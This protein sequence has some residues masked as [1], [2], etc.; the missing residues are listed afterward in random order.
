MRKNHIKK[1]KRS[2]LPWFMTM[3]FAFVTGCVPI[4]GLPVIPAGTTGNPVVTVS[5]NPSVTFTAPLNKASGVAFNQKPSVTFNEAMDPATINNSTLKLTGPGTEAVSGTVAYA[6]NT[7]TFTPTTGLTPNTVYSATITTGAKNPAGNSLSENFVWTFTTGS[8]PDTTSPV[9][10]STIP[11]ASENNVAINLKPT[12]TFSEPMDPLTLNTDIFSLS[13]GTQKVPGKV[14]YVGLI[15]TFTPD[16]NLAAN[17][18]YTATVTTQAKDLAGNPLAANFSW[19]F[20]TGVN[21]DTTMPVVISTTPLNNTDHQAIN[22]KPTVTFSEPMDPLTITTGTFILTGPGTSSVSGTVTY[23]GTTATFMPTFELAFDTLYT[24]TITTGARDL[25]GNALANNTVWT[26]RTGTGSSSSTGGNGGTTGGNNGNTNS[27]DNTA[28]AVTL[29][30]PVNGAPGIATNSKISATF[31]EAMSPATINDTTF[32][33]KQGVTPVAGTV[34]YTGLTA[35]FTPLVGLTANTAYTATITTGAKDLA[36]NALAANFV[37]SFTTSAAADT[38]APTVTSTVPAANAVGVPFNQKPAAT[39]SEAMD[40]ATINTLTFTLKQGITPVTGTVT[41]VGQTATFTPAVNLTAST[42]YTAT[43]TT[44]AKDLAGNALAA[45]V[46]WSFTTGAIADTTPP[47][48]TSTDPVDNATGVAFSQKPS[49]VFSEAMDPATINNVTF[50]LKQ[51]TTSVS[52]TVSYLGNT[53]TFSPLNPLESNKT[54]TATITSGARDLAGNLMTSSKIWTFSTITTAPPGV[55]LGAIAP[56]GGFGGGAGMTNQG[57]FTVINGDIGTTGASTLMTGFHDTK[58]TAST[59]DDTNFTVTPLN[60]GTVNGTIFT[61]TAPSGSVPGVT[62]NAA[63]LDAQTAFNNLSPA[64]LPGGIDVSTLGGGAGEL[65]ARVLAPGVYQSAPGTYAISL[66]DLTLDAQND[67]NAVWVFQ[68]ASSLT[69]GIA[70][71][72]GAR[73]VKLVNGALAKNVFWQVGSNAVINAAG[74]GTMVGTIIAAAGVTFSTAGNV[75]LTR[76]DGRAI[77]LNAS[78]TMVN[79]VINIPAP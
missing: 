25:A 68:M 77:G 74:G 57:L 79:T 27:G 30:V 31:S 71:P 55:A 45:D 9:V 7:A 38:T 52:G 56:F 32:T 4:S 42:I 64:A 1:F 78:V 3:L 43:I 6:G 24:A 35:T 23:L 76:L 5:G 21:T 29:T 17:T 40:P 16:N 10:T 50:T 44:G 65:G 20:T 14:T 15:A 63:A 73:N 69:V 60:N 19:S 12:V 47:T 46:I 75:V 51:G 70:G 11:T 41:Y 72:T 48:V 58:N 18:V 67:P 28:P 53:A 34:N 36:G 61:A 13:Q 62:A 22:L 54:F 33:L 26:F 37:W 2:I 8:A 59:L 66:G 39:F 49:A